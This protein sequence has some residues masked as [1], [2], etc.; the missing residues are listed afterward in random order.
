[1]KKILLIFL[2]VIAGITVIFLVQRKVKNT[3]LKS[4]K[5]EV[6]KKA[7]FYIVNSDYI[8]SYKLE[9]NKIKSLANEKH[10][11]ADYP[12]EMYGKAEFD[13]RY[14]VFSDDDGIGPSLGI[15]RHI[16]S[17]DFKTGKIKRTPTPNFGYSGGGYSDDYFYSYQATT[18]DGGLFSFDKN[19]KQVDSY[20]FDKSMLAAPKF[21]GKD[22]KLFLVATHSAENGSDDYENSLIVF[23]EKPKLKIA[24]TILLD[25]MPDYTYRP[26]ATEMVADSVYITLTSMRNRASKEVIPD[27]R[28]MVVDTKNYAKSF[29]E[30]SEDYPSDIFKSQDS[31]Y[32]FIT[33]PPSML[34]KSV[35][36][37]YNLEDKSQYQIDVSGYSELTDPMDAS[38]IS[39]NQ[40]K[41]NKLLILTHKVLLVY[42]LEKQELV[43]KLDVSEENTEDIYIWTN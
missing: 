32:L 19:G 33:H 29:I 22:G 8:K 36:T 9:G 38:I 20:Q 31:K 40:T 43:S 28:L 6:Q 16:I 4:D 1:M 17:I 14:L 10:K 15:N 25:D 5:F 11:I 34:G 26:N 27:N 12:N 41:D 37:V 7:D 21:V 18:E 3:V 13:N 42:D 35:L 39:A 30:L 24:K 2:I 23:D